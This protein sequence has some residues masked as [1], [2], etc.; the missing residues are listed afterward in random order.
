MNDKVLRSPVS[1]EELAQQP[2]LV[3]APIKRQRM[4][5]LVGKSC[6]LGVG[7]L[8]PV[9]TQRV[10]IERMSVERL[11]T[12]L[13]EAAEQC[14]RLT[15][16]I[17]EEPRPLADLLKAWPTDR[18][19]FVGNEAGQSPPL[20]SVALNCVTVKERFPPGFG[21]GTSSSPPSSVLSWGFMVGPEGGFD[22]KEMD[23]ISS[24]SFVRLVGLGPRILRAETAALVGL[25]LLQAILGDFARSPQ[26]L[27]IKPNET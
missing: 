16:P 9:V 6:E 7:R 15:V 11:Q 10:V 26:R 21:S 14:E 12:I 4:D 27:K 22:P 5:E 13:N 20:L 17:L 18:L 23:F 19:L 1:K 3:V 24:H 25:S 8:L 2:W